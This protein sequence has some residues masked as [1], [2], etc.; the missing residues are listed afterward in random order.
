MAGRGIQIAIKTPKKK[1]TQELPSPIR[2]CPSN[3]PS[4]VTFFRK[5]DHTNEA[6]RPASLEEGSPSHAEEKHGRKETT[7]FIKKTS[8]CGFSLRSSP[9]IQ[10]QVPYHELQ[11]RSGERAKLKT[12]MIQRG[13]LRVSV[14]SVRFQRP[15]P[16]WRTSP[17]A[18]NQSRRVTLFTALR[19]ALRSRPLVPFEL[20]YPRRN[21]K[22]FPDSGLR[23]HFPP[24]R[25]RSSE[26]C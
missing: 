19:D 13:L 17:E 3:P 24:P 26:F 21:F 2:R 22:S 23:G 8:K 12:L 18:L 6:V 5:T 7:A 1:K 20:V 16:K 15:T 9:C 14:L 11:A 25:L 10:R 4:A